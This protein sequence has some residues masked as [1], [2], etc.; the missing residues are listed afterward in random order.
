MLPPLLFLLRILIRCS[1]VSCAGF[2]DVCLCYGWCTLLLD[3]GLRLFFLVIK[4]E[5]NGVEL[6]G[7]VLGE[8]RCVSLSHTDGIHENQGVGLALF[9]LRFAVLQ[10]LQTGLYDN[11]HAVLQHAHVLA[12]QE[13]SVVLILGSNAVTDVL[14]EVLLPLGL[15]RFQMRQSLV[16]DVFGDC[17]V[18][19]RF[20]DQIVHSQQK[21]VGRLL[22]L[23]GADHVGSPDHGAVCLV[24]QT[25]DRDNDAG[26][27]IVLVR[28]GGKLQVVSATA[29]DGGLQAPVELHGIEVL[30]DL[31][32]L[33]ELGV[34]DLVRDLVGE[35]SVGDFLLRVKNVG[36]F[37]NEVVGHEG[38]GCTGGIADGA[39]GNVSITL[40][41]TLPLLP[42]SSFS[43]LME[44]AA[45]DRM[46]AR[47][48]W[49]SSLMPASANA[50]FHSSAKPPV[51]LSFLSTA[52]FLPAFLSVS[53]HVWN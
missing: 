5:R 2:G 40:D 24:T 12:A 47:S 34:V 51:E 25:K 31:L 7:C 9:V 32:L 29:L 45:C 11:G 30:G 50:A 4:E 20:D 14:G 3:L 38:A 37:L 17:A 43:S 21:L 52:T 33:E 22:L 16:V 49:S 23:V 53:M 10:V 15:L 8:D 6:G 19:D 28:F 26:V 36:H 18:L 42:T 39:L 48:T 41:V 27:E 46:G 35:G 1:L 44:R 13:Q